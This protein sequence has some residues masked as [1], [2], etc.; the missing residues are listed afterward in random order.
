LLLVVAWP[1]E[2]PTWPSHP[3]RRIGVT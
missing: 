3:D 1:P 2:S